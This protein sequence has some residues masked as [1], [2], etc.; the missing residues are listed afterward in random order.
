MLPHQDYQIPQTAIRSNDDDYG[1]HEKTHVTWS[2]TTHII[3]VLPGLNLRFC[4]QK[5]ASNHLRYGTTQLYHSKRTSY[6]TNLLK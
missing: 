6:I 3:L 1:T 5:A 4:D 2:T